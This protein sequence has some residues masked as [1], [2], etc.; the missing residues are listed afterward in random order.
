MR[1]RVKDMIKQKR[2]SNLKNMIKQKKKLNLKEYEKMEK[3]DS[4]PENTVNKENIEEV[5]M[6]RHVLFINTFCIQVHRYYFC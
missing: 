2:K 1:K 5:T 6:I 3:K 4:E